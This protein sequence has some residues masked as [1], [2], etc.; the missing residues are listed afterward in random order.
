[1]NATIAA[2]LAPPALTLGGSPGAREPEL[3]WP[4]TDWARAT[5][6]DVGLDEDHAVRKATLMLRMASS[7][8][9]G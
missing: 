6:A 1:M 7:A 3:V 2:L 4:V 8:A 9:E 5:P